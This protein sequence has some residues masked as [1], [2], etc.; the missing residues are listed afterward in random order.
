MTTRL[1]D[2]KGDHACGL[3][4]IGDLVHQNRVPPEIS[5]YCDSGWDSSEPNV[6][7]GEY[8]YNEGQL[9]KLTKNIPLH[10]H[11]PVVNTYGQLRNILFEHGVFQLQLPILTG[12]DYLQH[13]HSSSS[14]FL[15]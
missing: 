11:A 13:E 4:E 14:T 9:S 10:V 15:K 12:L 2:Q 5:I 3:Q 7:L 6:R 8:N 1:K